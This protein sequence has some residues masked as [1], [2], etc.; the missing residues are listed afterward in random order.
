MSHIFNDDTIL[1]KG[2]RVKLRE[3]GSKRVNSCVNPEE[4]AA[5]RSIKGRYKTVEKLHNAVVNR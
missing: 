1:L 4:L 3:I 5:K 2:H